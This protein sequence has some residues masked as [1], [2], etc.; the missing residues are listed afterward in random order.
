M[1]ERLRRWREQARRREIARLDPSEADVRGRAISAGIDRHVARSGN[2][3]GA[4]DDKGA[5][6]GG[7]RLG[8]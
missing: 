3:S 4:F 6:G 7:T 5:L 8:G 2:E 1:L